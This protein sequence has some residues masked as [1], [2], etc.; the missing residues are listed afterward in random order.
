MVRIDHFRAVEQNWAIPA[1]NKTARKGSWEKGPGAAL[2]Q[3]LQEVSGP[4]ELVAEDLGTITPGVIA[5]RREFGIPGM[6]VL[7]FAF[8]DDE[9]NNPHR[10]E[11]IREDVICYTGT[12]DNDT[13]VGWFKETEDAREPH[14]R[15]RRQRVTSLMR[16]D[17]KPHQTLIRTAM[18]SSARIAI[19][20]MQDLLGLD[21]DAR[22]NFPGRI[23]GNWTW[24]MNAGQLERVDWDWFEE[25]TLKTGRMK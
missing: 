3:A 11:N 25:L 24:R 8:D 1:R 4:H 14:L 17:E 12:H 15:K 16:D 19:I 21:S 9:V 18:E 7:Q 6:A 5:L 22:M 2:L 23:E 10:P 13:T 20:P